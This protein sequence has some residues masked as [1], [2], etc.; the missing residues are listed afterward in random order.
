MNRKIKY[1]CWVASKMWRVYSLDFG[2]NDEIGTRVN[3]SENGSLG[4][5]LDSVRLM[6]FTNVVD[7]MGAEVY[8]GDIISFC[9][10]QDNFHRFGFVFWSKE[11]LTYLVQFE[12]GASDYC[13]EF[14]YIV[15]MKNFAVVGNVFQNKNLI[16]EELVKKY[17]P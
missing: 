7:T 16:R 6:Q 3:V 17:F 13:S 14:L 9:N 12:M 5:P 4:F 2:N 11:Y 15:N 8:E 10:G 1:R